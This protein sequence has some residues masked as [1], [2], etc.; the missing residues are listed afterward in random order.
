MMKRSGMG[1]RGAAAGMLMIILTSTTM[2]EPPHAMPN[3]KLTPGVVDPAA[4][5]AIV[6]TPNYTAGAR[7]VTESMK[8]EVFVRYGIVDVGVHG[9]YEVDHLIS[10]EIGG[11]NDVKNLWPQA[12]CSLDK[13]GT[14][15]FGAREKDHAENFLH[16][17]VCAGRMTLAQAQAAIV[18]DWFKVY[19][20]WKKTQGAAA[21]QR[22]GN[23]K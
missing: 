5:V 12:Y 8:N 1:K 17:E 15:C 13:G 4:T 18:K 14:V 23:T 3:R 11:A 21:P 9:L 22:T 2:A 20:Q 7:N 16:R 10:L 19:L 6:C